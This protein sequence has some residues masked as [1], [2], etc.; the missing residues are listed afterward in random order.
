VPTLAKD[1]QSAYLQL[2]QLSGKVEQMIEQSVVA[3]VNKDQAKADEIIASDTDVD[4]REVQIEEVCLT[5][6][7]LHQPVAADLRRITMMIKINNELEQMADLAC[8]IA[9]R[10]KSLDPSSQ[11]AIPASMAPMAEVVRRMVKDSLN[12]FINADSALAR[13]VL[14]TDD[15]VDR[16]NV[17]VIHAVEDS[18][19][20]VC[21][22]VP[23]ALHCFSASRHLEQIADHATSI[24]ED[25]IYM[26]EGDIVR[27]R[28][29]LSEESMNAKE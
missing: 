14:E 1:L 25:V 2:I 28:R 10:T 12:A 8:N 24:A 16:L 20:Q 3:L 11:F 4:R 13:R 21:H 9:E 7:A 26:A 19:Q 22:S 29:T 17:Q 6:L 27:H 5:M 15:E 18:I 23:E